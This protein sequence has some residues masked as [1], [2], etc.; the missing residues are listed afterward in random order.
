M[1]FSKVL[2]RSMSVR[3]LHISWELRDYNPGVDDFQFYVLRSR[4]PHSDYVEIAGPL[5]SSMNTFLDTS[6]GR[7]GTHRDYFYRIEIRGN[8]L[9][10]LSH[11]DNGASLEAE[12]TLPALEIA[13]TEQV[14]LREYKGRRVLLFQ[15]RHS[16]ARCMECFNTL[17]MK[18]TK[19]NCVSCFNTG[20]ALGFY[21]PVVVYAQIE[22]P[23]AVSL[24]QPEGKIPIRQS[25]MKFGHFP[26]LRDGDLVVEAENKR[27]LVG[28]NQNRPALGRFV[29]RQE[30]TVVQ[31]DTSNIEY[32]VPINVDADDWF[33]T[34]VRAMTSPQDLG[35]TNYTD[36]L[37]AAFTRRGST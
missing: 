11:C 22:E 26:L 5:Q 34:P 8:G 15:R 33:G 36:T 31:L 27:W 1:E 23:R 10:E 32:K 28:G 18:R 14:V 30:V 13:R 12:A 7:Y 37:A 20:Y 3:S 19:S 16:G 21:R 25:M 6:V 35:T 29:V 4:N 2:V 9:S 24:T 17:R